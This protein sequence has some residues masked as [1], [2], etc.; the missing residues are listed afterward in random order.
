[1]TKDERTSRAFKALA[2]PRRMRLFRLLAERPETGD[3]ILK[4]YTAARIPE[5][6][7]RHH[8]S[9]MERSGLVRRRRVGRQVRAILTPLALQSAMATANWLVS[10]RR[11]RNQVA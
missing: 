1:M 7:F 6:S 10:Q 5:A 4:L 3:S 8:L 9:E 11:P 2:H